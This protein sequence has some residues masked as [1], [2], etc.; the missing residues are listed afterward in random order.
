MSTTPTSRA[1]GSFSRNPG[2]AA[3]DRAVTSV[4]V[5]KKMRTDPTSAW[6]QCAAV[7]TALGAITY[8]SRSQR[9]SVSVAQVDQEHW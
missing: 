6:R 2:Y 8:R 1:E 5:P 4:P 3:N 7:S 9:E